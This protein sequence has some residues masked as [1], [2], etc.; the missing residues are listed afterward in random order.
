VQQPRVAVCAKRLFWVR[1]A[2][3]RK[4]KCG[5]GSV[6]RASPCQGEGREFESRH[7]LEAGSSRPARKHGGV[8]ERPKAAACKAVKPRVQIPS[9]PQKKQ[10]SSFVRSRMVLARVLGKRSIGAAVAHFLDMEGVTGSIPVS[11]TNRPWLNA[12]VF[13]FKRMP[14]PCFWAKETRYAPMPRIVG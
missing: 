5:C 2:L 4:N 7:P 12:G 1:V 11:T 6:G 8:A 3:V 9:P 13:F 10:T 14:Y